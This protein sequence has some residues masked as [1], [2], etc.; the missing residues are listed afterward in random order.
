[1]YYINIS[2]KLTLILVLKWNFVTPREEF[3]DLL[4]DQMSSAGLNK[5]LV[6]NMFHNDFR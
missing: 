1:M 3:F 4:K 6:S 5:N 2:K